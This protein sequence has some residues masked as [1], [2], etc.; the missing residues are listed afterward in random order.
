M[1]TLP[2]PIRSP[3]HVTLIGHDQRTPATGGGNAPFSDGTTTGRGDAHISLSSLAKSPSLA[4]STITTAAL[5]LAVYAST[6]W[7]TGRSIPEAYTQGPRPGPSAISRPNTCS[8]LTWRNNLVNL[9][10]CARAAAAGHAAN[11]PLTQ[12]ADREEH[13]TG[14]GTAVCGRCGLLRKINWP[15]LERGDSATAIPLRVAS[16]SRIRY[17]I[18]VESTDPWLAQGTPGKLVRPE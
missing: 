2:A 6:A 16:R 18:Q 1:I 11:W 9:R 14:A 5:A 3:A 17:G 12:G 7:H 15:G 13:G 10:A 4:T 8:A